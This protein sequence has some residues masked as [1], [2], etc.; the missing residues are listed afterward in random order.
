MDVNMTE[1]SLV[2]QIKFAITFRGYTVKAFG[3]EFNKR[4][5]TNYSPPSFSRKLSRGSFNLDELKIISEI[6]GF[7]IKFELND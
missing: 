1:R 6:L 7:T 2:E 4:C 3:E 5:Q